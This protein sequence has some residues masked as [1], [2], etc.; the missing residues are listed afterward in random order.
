MTMKCPSFFIHSTY[1]LFITCRQAGVGHERFLH[2][3]SH[4]QSE[5]SAS[6]RRFAEANSIGKCVALYIFIFPTCLHYI[7]YIMQYNTYNIEVN[8]WVLP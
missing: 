6:S 4:L 5:C 3:R 7:H 1:I 8:N 2:H